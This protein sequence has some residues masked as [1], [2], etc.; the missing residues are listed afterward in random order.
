MALRGWEG[1]SEGPERGHVF[2]RCIAG[3]A[4][5]PNGS[6]S[7][8]IV[9]HGNPGVMAGECGVVISVWT[10]ADKSLHNCEGRVQLPLREAHEGVVRSGKVNFVR[11]ANA[12]LEDTVVLLFP[13]AFI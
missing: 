6:C 12:V 13:D 11:R 9:H 8:E 7:E 5:E 10:V 4:H 1:A 3:S 2:L